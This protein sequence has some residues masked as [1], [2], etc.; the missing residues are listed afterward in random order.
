MALLTF[1]FDSLQICGVCAFIVLYCSVSF[2]YLKPMY[3]LFGSV[4]CLMVLSPNEEPDI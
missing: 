1:K 4:R 3:V 2:Y